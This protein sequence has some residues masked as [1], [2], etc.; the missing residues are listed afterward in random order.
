MIVEPDLPDHPKTHKLARLLSIEADRVP[1]ILVRLW[2][3]CQNRRSEQL[4]GNKLEASIDVAVICRWPGES[5]PFL[6]ALISSG[7][8]DQ[9]DGNF[10]VRGW[11]ERNSMWLSR[12]EGGKK[13]SENA[14]R[15]SA[16]QLAGKTRRARTKLDGAQQLPSSQL[17]GLSAGGEERRGEE[18]IPPNVPQGG[19][20]GAHPSESS[21]LET[22]K[23][24][25]CSIFG[26]KNRVLHPSA[27]QA[28]VHWLRVGILP[29]A[30]DDERALVAYYAARPKAGD[31]PHHRR[32][33]AETLAEHLSSELDLAH[34]WAATAKPSI[35]DA[36]KTGAPLGDPPGCWEWLSSAYPEAPRPARWSLLPESI[37]SEFTLSQ[38]NAAHP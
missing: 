23:T 12:I 19:Q 25:L 36:K 17:A 9:I 20:S 27:D 22:A 21:I 18:N 37:R 4:A 11:R 6:D 30:P 38:K 24:L 5:L 29:L 15:N 33:K 10:T 32:Q 7:W 3:H 14:V 1:S 28:L 26:K 13:R 34:Q 31:D 2:G 8:I 16:G 35:F